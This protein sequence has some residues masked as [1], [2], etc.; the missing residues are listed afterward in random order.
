MTLALFG[1]CNP[2]ALEKRARLEIVVGV[3]DMRF[4]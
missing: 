2:S 3:R 1:G 4:D